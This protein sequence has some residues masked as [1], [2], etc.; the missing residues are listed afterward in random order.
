MRVLTEAADTASNVAQA[1]L[2]GSTIALMSS[3]PAAAFVISQVISTFTLLS[4][5]NGPRMV[6]PDAVFTSLMSV[7]LIDLGLQ[8]GFDEY[9]EDPQEVPI[10]D[11]TD[12]LDVRV[13]I[14]KNAGED[15]VFLIILLGINL[16]FTASS[17]LFLH[18]SKQPEGSWS[19]KV[20]NFVGK[21]YGVP[22]FAAEVDS[23]AMELLTFVWANLFYASTGSGA[24]KLS[25]ALSTGLLAL[26]LGLA[27]LDWKVARG[28]APQLKDVNN[29]QEGSLLEKASIQPSWLGSLAFL[30]EGHSSTVSH[31]ALYSPLI[32]LCR[33]VL[34]TGAVLGLARAGVSQLIVFGVIELGY[35]FVMLKWRWKDSTLDHWFFVI[36]E[37]WDMCYLV[38]KLVSWANMSDEYR[39]VTMGTILSWII[40]SKLIFAACYCVLTLMREI[41][42][43]IKNLIARR[44][45]TGVSS[46][47]SSKVELEQATIE[48]SKN[49][50]TLVVKRG[51]ASEVEMKV[52]TQADSINPFSREP[53]PA[54]RVTPVFMTKSSS[55]SKPEAA[56]PMRVKYPNHYS[57]KGRQ[58]VIPIQTSEGG[59]WSFV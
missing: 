41:F 46:H 59:A 36:M 2:L 21:S 6:L 29:S 34:S 8:D 19:R 15:L 58:R 40:L 18:L 25:V 22:Y 7:K 1:V 35:I 51:S 33:A 4:L 45:R 17:K 38:A 3:N 12:R 52:Q 31:I 30:W 26:Y 9:A 42:F 10:S 13:S 43:A 28:L 50:S 48:Q 56:S 24:A 27:W 54:K 47:D 44:K 5:L 49:T 53:S 32:G 55:S 57:A 16:V 23:S 14:I 20:A 11:T 39:Q 37:A